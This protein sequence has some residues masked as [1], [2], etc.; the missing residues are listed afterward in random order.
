MSLPKKISPNPLF[1]STVEIRFSSSI[2]GSENILPLIYGKFM[3][4]LPNLESKNIP[5]DIKEREPRLRYNADFVL[6]NKDFSLSFS[7]KAIAFENVSDY[8]FWDNYFPFISNQLKQIF[9]MNFISKIERIGVRYASVLE[10]AN[11]ITN[12]LKYNPIMGIEG[13]EE[14][15]NLLR[16]ILSKDD[17]KLLLQIA[18]NSKSVKNEISR[19]G[20]LIDIDA[21]YTGNLNPSDEVLQK[22]DKLHTFQKELFFSLL[23][24]EFLETLNPTY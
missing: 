15:L 16:T 5:K 13:Y 22:I 12:A 17:C 1:T 21:S 7:D 3:N 8:M 19:I 4:L 18:P 20:L 14:N 11:I 24:P 2:A 10:N 9:E 23:K 6:K